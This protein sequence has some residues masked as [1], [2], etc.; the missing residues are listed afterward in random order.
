MEIVHTRE[1]PS[2][3]CRAVRSCTRVEEKEVEVTGRKKEG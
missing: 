2:S 3:S 1:L